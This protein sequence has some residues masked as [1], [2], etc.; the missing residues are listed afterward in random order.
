MLPENFLFKK[1]LDVL[2]EEIFAGDNRACFIEREQLLNESREHISGLPELDRYAFQ[3]DYLLSRVSTPVDEKDLIVGRLVEGL[4]S[5]SELKCERLPGELFSWGHITLGW[6][7]LLNTGLSEI[8]EIAKTSAKKLDTEESRTFL[9]NAESCVRAIEKYSKRYAEAV[10][11]KAET[12]SDSRVKA[13]LL[14]TVLALENGF[15]KPAEDFFSALQTIW[16][17]HLITSCYI[18]SRDFA[19]GRMDQYLYPYYRR[20]IDSGNLNHKEALEILA[21]F[22]IKCNEITGTGTWNYQSKPIPSK[23]S[24]QYLIIGGLCTDGKENFNELSELIVEA[25]CLVKMPQPTI[26]FRLSR[27]ISQKAGA[28]AGK[29][30]EQ[31]GSQIHFY[32]DSLICPELMRQGVG[33]QDAF[34]YTMVGCC[35]LDIQGKTHGFLPLNYLYHNIVEW[36]LDAL[37]G[38]GCFED[39]F[40]NFWKVCIKRFDKIQQ[41]LPSLKNKPNNFHIESLLT[42]DC[43]DSCRDNYAGGARYNTQGHFLGGIATIANSLIAVKKLVFEQKRFT[44]NQFM[45]IAGNNFEENEALRQEIINRLPKFGNG[46]E[47][48]DEL[49]EKTAEILLEALYK[50]KAP[51]GT[52]KL[53]GFYT[54]DNHH[55]WGKQLPGT[56]DGRIQ[57]EPVSENQSPVYG[58][59]LEGVTALL[60]SVSSLPLK[61]TLMGGLNVKFGNAVSGEKLAD[62]IRTYFKMDGLHL[63]FSIVDKSTLEDARIH[64]DEYRSLCVRMYGFSEYFVSLSPHEQQEL[65]DR[66]EYR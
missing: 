33:E 52:V 48:V 66:T 1:D 4:L 61:K 15:M 6:E 51:K 39:F 14:R 3:L 13:R 54:L 25:A 53:S 28:L 29:A 20:D 18:G 45:D 47:E 7:K 46:I 19:F 37:G 40:D 8:L 2:K 10:R 58:T 49:A 64:P 21:H 35:R 41:E 23:A 32:N 59:D 27:G 60:K 9:K 55:A 50:S 31:L 44:L 43:L 65:I 42:D 63:G 57:G 56:P 11:K 38:C 30:A 24:K 62:L 17:M 34:D 16:L 12:V 5:E 22:M 26:T 36:M